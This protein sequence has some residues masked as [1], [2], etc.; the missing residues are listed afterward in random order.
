MT[1][2]RRAVLLTLMALLAG[3]V[4]G[5]A[6][7]THP[8]GGTLIRWLEPVGLLWVNAIRMTVIPLIVSSLVV[9]VASAEP[10][11]LGK[12]GLRTA[13]AFLFLL[14]SMAVVATLLT[15][16]LFGF[17]HLDPAAVAAV[18]EGFTSETTLPALPSFSSWVVSLVPTNPVAAAA[19]GAMLPLVVF[20]VAFALALGRI[21]ATQRAPVVEFFRAVSQAMTVLVG[22]I[23]VAAPIG[24]FALTFG[25]AARTGTELVG[26]A[27]F[28]IAAASAL[29]V[30]G[31]LVVYVVV[32]LFGKVSLPLF[33]RAALP[34][35]LV[36]ITTRSSMAALPANVASA[37]EILRLPTT[38][39]SLVLPL[40]VSSFRLNQPL[41][42]V[43]MAVFSA[44]LFGVEL[45]FATV[46]ILAITAVLMSFSVPGIP[47]ASL[48]VVAPF[49]VE[50]GIPPEAIGILIAL[51]LIPDVFK[52]TLNV[53]GHLAAATLVDPTRELREARGE[54]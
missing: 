26:A 49:F 6:V 54:K 42:W 24:A 14:A 4:L 5:V 10:Q 47:S 53:T 7:S 38:T 17:M 52:T 41:S 18:R 12:L 35:Q 22:W 34:A 16:W 50:I 3:M 39:T 32:A 9:A 51:D 8:V 29:L 40:A 25:V 27:G 48:F 45:S 23:L 1:T 19:D 13:A 31:V 44:A 43:T 20:T 2:S 28:Y 21:A 11:T 15:P 46:A 37:E 30:V 36:A 33:A